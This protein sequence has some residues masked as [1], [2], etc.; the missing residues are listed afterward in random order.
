MKLRQEEFP[1]TLNSH[2]AR[3]PTTNHTA[4][5]S[6]MRGTPSDSRDFVSWIYVVS[7]TVR[8]K[9]PSRVHGLE[10]SIRP[11]YGAGDRDQRGR[12]WR[13]AHVRRVLE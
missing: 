3:D 10:G 7:S 11:P 8:S 2:T 12:P 5:R 1:C 6:D 9:F 4:A 13:G